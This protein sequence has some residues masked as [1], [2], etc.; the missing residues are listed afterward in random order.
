MFPPGAR[1]TWR[2]ER[3]EESPAA[4]LS[5]TDGER[6]ISPLRE[7]QGETRGDQGVVATGQIM[8]TNIIFYSIENITS[9]CKTQFVNSDLGNYLNIDT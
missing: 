6:E 2:G 8:G 4:T 7:D 9:L 5:A 3:R 1:L